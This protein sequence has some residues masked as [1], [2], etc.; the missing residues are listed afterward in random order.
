MPP[1]ARHGSVGDASELFELRRRKWRGSPQDELWRVVGENNLYVG[2]HGGETMKTR[3]SKT[4]QENSKN[5]LGGDLAYG[6]P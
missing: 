3:D 4:E 6:A 2:V 5:E 1:A